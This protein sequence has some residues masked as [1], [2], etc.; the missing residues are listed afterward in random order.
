[1]DLCAAKCSEK[2]SA[3]VYFSHATSSGHFILLGLHSELSYP[4]FI[5]GGLEFFEKILEGTG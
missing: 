2:C 1:M 5:E 4:L 3:H